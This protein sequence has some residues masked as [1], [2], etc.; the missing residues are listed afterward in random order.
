MQKIGE[1]LQVFVKIV[2][3]VPHFLAL[4]L[5]NI[6]IIVNLYIRIE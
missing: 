2:A 1:N 4:D 3:E 6:A 5:T